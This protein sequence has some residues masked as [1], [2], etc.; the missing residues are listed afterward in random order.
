MVIHTLLYVCILQGPTG[1]EGVYRRACETTLR[2]MR[3]QSDPLMSVLKTFIYDPLVEWS[4]PV[5]GR[6]SESGEI[7]NEKV[8]AELVLLCLNHCIA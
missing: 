5:K 8:T 6:S 7:K 1:Y 4:K 3:N 2:V